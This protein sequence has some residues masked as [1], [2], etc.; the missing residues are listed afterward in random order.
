MSIG[1]SQ[2]FKK[3]QETLELAKAMKAELDAPHTTHLVNSFSTFPFSY[4]QGVRRG[5][6][7]AEDIASV[8]DEGCNM[9]AIYSKLLKASSG[10][11]QNE[12]KETGFT[13][14][15][16]EKKRCEDCKMPEDMT[17]FPSQYVL[18]QEKHVLIFG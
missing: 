9:I 13:C 3:C 2:L 7:W 8:A 11:Y 4:V 1:K 10:F 6:E 16:R 17:C 5:E 14:Y 18:R 12:T 15:S